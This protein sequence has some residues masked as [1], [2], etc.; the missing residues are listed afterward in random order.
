MLGHIIASGAEF[1]VRN[2]LHNNYNSIY[3]NLIASVTHEITEQLV[4]FAFVVSLSNISNF[5][6]E[7]TVELH[8]DN[9]VDSAFEYSSYFP[10]YLTVVCGVTGGIVG[11]QVSK[12]MHIEKY[13]SHRCGIMLDSCISTAGSFLGTTIA[14]LIERSYTDNLV[15]DEI[16][17]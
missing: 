3:L 6:V 12:S 7:Q 10:S 5:T 1:C 4:N 16:L 15:D 9:N 13:L 8:Q 2:A 14:S 11:G 17:L